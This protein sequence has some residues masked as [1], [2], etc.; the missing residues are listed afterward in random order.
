V[1]ENILLKHQLLIL[2][3]SRHR[4]PNLRCGDRVVFGSFHSS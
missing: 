1:A 4:A 2:R 3:R